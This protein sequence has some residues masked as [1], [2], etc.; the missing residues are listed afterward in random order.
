LLSQLATAVRVA[1]SGKGNAGSV[2]RDIA[3]AVNSFNQRSAAPETHVT[4]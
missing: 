3:A 2:I 1:L 4:A